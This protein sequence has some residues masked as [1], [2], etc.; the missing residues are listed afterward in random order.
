MA[1]VAPIGCTQYA[2]CMSTAAH[3]ADRLTA[4]VAGRLSS[5][6][7][8]T[9]PFTW[10]R[11]VRELEIALVDAPAEIQGAIH[12]LIGS[13]RMKLGQVDLALMEHQQAA[14]LEP[15]VA[16][17]QN[18]IAWD[19]LLLKRPAEALNY[20][21]RGRAMRGTS[22][23]VEVRIRVNEVDALLQLGDPAEAG[24]ALQAAMDRVHATDEMNL[25]NLA[26]L[27]AQMGRDADSIEMYA[28]FAEAAGLGKR[29]V[30]QS[31]LDFLR[32]QGASAMDH[33]LPEIRDA[34]VR[35]VLNSAPEDDEDLGPEEERLIAEGREAMAKGDVLST[36]QL[37]R[38]LNLG[39]HS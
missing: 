30:D 9:D 28:R 37:V 19:L 32:H 27:T 22:R 21:R 34:V 20:L 11:Y 13:C 36:D 35:A 2:Q 15:T 6:T 29:D 18:N 3:A 31:A 1:G 38:D 14:K 10:R 4:E 39:P 5:Y 26:S 33:A 23:E 24:R 17:H 7:A 8:D 12:N 16:S 25:L